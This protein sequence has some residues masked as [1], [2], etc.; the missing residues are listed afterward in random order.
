MITLTIDG[1][2]VKVEEGTSVLDA[3]R[4]AQV[5]VPTL[6]KHPD[7]EAT[8]AC[9]ICIVKINGRMRRSCCTP[10][11]EGMQVITRDPDIMKARK[12]IVELILSRHPNDCLSCLKNGNCELQDLAREF[13][14][15]KDTFDNITPTEKEMP[16]DDSTGCIQI[17]PRKCVQ[18]GRCVQ[19]CQKVQNVYALSSLKR[20][21]NTL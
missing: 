8:A 5:I 3:C 19:V 17:D 2:E 1:I 16:V 11:A 13:S 14:L 10:V 18:C 9:G 15:D 7:L 4:A 21:I 6:C 12:T 20:G